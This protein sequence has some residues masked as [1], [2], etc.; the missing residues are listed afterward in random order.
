MGELLTLK[1]AG[2]SN[3][4]KVATSIVKS[5]QEGK[6]IEALAIGAG[7]VNQ[8][9][10]A[11]TIARGQAAPAGIDLTIRPGFADI[12]IDGEI[13]TALKLIVVVS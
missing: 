13:K 5:I 1:I 6:S 9:V 8:A 11:I 3:P 2:T 4:T 10:K 7:A 12:N